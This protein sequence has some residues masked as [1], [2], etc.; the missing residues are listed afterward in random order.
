MLAAIRART[1][2]PTAIVILTGPVDAAI[3]GATVF[4][5]HGVPV[6]AHEAAAKLIA[7]RCHA[8]LRNLANRLGEDVMAGTRV[9][10]PDR[11]FKGSRRL[12]VAGRSLELLDYSGAAAPGSIAIWDRRSGFV[13][14][15]GL[16]S[17]GRIP[18]TRDG[19][20]ADWI[21][22]LRDLSGRPARAIVPAHGPVGD[23]A[24]L[25][26]VAAYLSALGE[27]TA[28]AYAARVSLLD[29]PRMVAIPEYRR[30]ALYE[31]AHPRN[32]HHAYLGEERREL[33]KPPENP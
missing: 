3:F 14:A 13:F 11:L 19:V 25:E 33:A 28:Q 22:A 26:S 7:E 23:R 18:E 32:V 17:F 21:E 5:R 1:G 12:A 15:G 10:R 16:A 30:W 29:A 20:L 9:P 24:A 8:C 27:R 6:L 2:K 31:S 4:Q